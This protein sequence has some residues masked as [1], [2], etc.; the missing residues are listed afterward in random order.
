MAAT[1]NDLPAA[2]GRSRRPVVIL[3]TALGLLFLLPLLVL[4]STSWTNGAFLTVPPQGFSLRWYTS[5]LSDSDWTDAFQLSLWLSA[6][7]ALIATVL[8]TS[9]ALGLSRLRAARSGRLVR[10]LFVL[11]LAV[12]YISYALGLY[13]LTQRLPFLQLTYLPVVLGEALLAFPLVFVV[14]SGALARQDPRLRPAA[15]TLGAG[16][17][18]TVW[19]VELPLL[20]GSIAAG[21]LFAFNSAFDEVVLSVFV[22]PVGHTTLPLQMLNASREAIS[23]QLTAA[24][25]LVSL[26]A[27][28]VLSAPGLARRTVRRKGTAR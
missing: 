6:A 16:W 13:G 8:G 27:V 3:T 5:L 2:L 21:A 26:L 11:P 15:A 12:P 19:R 22:L 4:V 18:T 20:T 23:P 17:F 24:S 1:T 9:A 25:T 14:V 28:V 10:G 7:S